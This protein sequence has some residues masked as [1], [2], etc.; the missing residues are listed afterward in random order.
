MSATALSIVVP[1]FREAGNL[2]ALARRIE[3]TMRAAGLEWELIVVDDDSRDGIEQVVAELSDDM[4]VRLEVR[5]APRRDLSLSVVRGMELAHHDVV[6][7]MDADLSHP[8]E[9]IPELLASLSEGKPMVVGSRYLPGSS[10][11][12]EWGADRL[13]QS[14]LATI[15]TKPLV[16]CADPMSGFFAADLRQLPVLSELR[17]IGF[18]IGLELMVRGELDVVEVPIFFKDR[19]VGQSKMNARQQINY[20]RH[21]WRLYLFRFGRPGRMV[22]FVMVG[23]SGLLV[24]IAVFWGIRWAGVDHRVARLISFWIAASW[25]WWLNRNLTFE[26]RP[27]RRPGW[28]WVKFVGGSLVGFGANFGSYLALTGMLDLFQ[29]NQTFALI[30]GVALGTAANYAMATL[31][32]F[33][34]AGRRRKNP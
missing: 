26:E 15:L 25:N 21:L 23:S 3:R 11:D 1:T 18:K 10:L 5:I 4:P 29:R 33:P 20:L 2:E 14:R 16:S 13:L 8:P 28:Q 30:C 19:S 27:K 22:S 31:F 32:V 7:V 34:R 17:P 24:D 6:V 12:E 9:A